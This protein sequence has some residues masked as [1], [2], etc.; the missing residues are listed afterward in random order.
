MGAEVAE[1]SRLEIAVSYVTLAVAGLWALF[2]FS[3]N[4][5]KDTF[6][7]N[8]KKYGMVADLIKKCSSNNQDEQN[9]AL[10]FFGL[11]SAGGLDPEPII[12][13]FG[14]LDEF[15]KLGAVCATIVST[16]QAVRPGQR[17]ND[18]TQAAS[19]AAGD[20]PP[21]GPKAAGGPATT[22][23][24]SPNDGDRF[25]IYIGTYNYKDRRWITKYVDIPNGFDPNVFS[26]ATDPKRGFYRVRDETGALNVRF[27]S[28]S[29]TGDFPPT[30]SRPLQ[31]GKEVHIKSMAQWFD[32]GNWWATIEPP[33]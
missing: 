25:W 29:A 23:S 2:G 30:T 26:V 17:T 12:E 8:T 24:A 33:Q 3:Y 19:K 32:S 5:S 21:P 9:D 6:E 15:N 4:I 1:K 7:R 10:Q 31:P 14:R 16:R 22:P 18:P 11:F 13:I 27:G 20:V 28:F